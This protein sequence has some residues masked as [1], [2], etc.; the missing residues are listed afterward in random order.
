MKFLGRL[1]GQ[2]PKMW[3]QLGPITAWPSR[4]FQGQVSIVLL[5]SDKRR[6]VAVVGESAY[7][8]TLDRI[9]GG[10]TINGCRE[11]DHTAVL[12]PEPTNR[13]DGNAVRV[14]VIPWGAS[15]GSGLVGYLSREDAVAYRPLIDRLADVGRLVA[16]AASLIGGWDRGGDDRGHIGVLLHIDTPEGALTEVEA[17]PESLLPAWDETR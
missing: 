13:Y 6:T 3:P 11:T 14:V 12:V 16:C 1:L 8:G 4:G 2:S 5:D 7:Q 10:R 15:N 17:D 9:G